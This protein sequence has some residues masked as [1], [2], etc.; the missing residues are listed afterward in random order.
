MYLHN[1]DV[2]D[3]DIYPDFISGYLSL[4]LNDGLHNIFMEIPDKDI[5]KKSSN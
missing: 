3:P 2:A 1:A 5:S 4:P